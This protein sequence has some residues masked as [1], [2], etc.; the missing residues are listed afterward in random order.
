MKVLK[1]LAIVFG[2]LILLTGAGLFAAS[3][4]VDK[5]ASTIDEQMSQNGLAGPVSG[6]ITDLDPGPPQQISVTYTDKQG[7]EQSGTG[8]VADTGT[9]TT[10]AV[11]DEVT[12]FYSTDSPDQVVV[13]DLPGGA[14]LAGLSGG[15]RTGGI[16]GMIL[17]GVLLIGGILASVLGKKKPPTGGAPG[18]GTAYP[19]QP[20]GPGQPQ[21]PNQPYPGPYP[22]QQPGGPQYP[23][24]GGQFGPQGGQFGPQGGQNFPP[25]GGQQY[26]PH[27]GQQNP[28]QPGGWQ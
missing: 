16:V 15:L 10:Y 13:V 28:P 9:G 2:V 25:Q 23:P 12:L 27:P 11:G 22:P 21:Q 18:Y 14:D 26:P 3:A 6:T 7:E 1:I 8:V 17:G 20:G 24:Q 4:V 5:G 19:N